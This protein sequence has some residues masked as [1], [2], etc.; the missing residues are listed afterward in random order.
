[1]AIKGAY[2]A[3][4]VADICLGAHIKSRGSGALSYIDRIYENP[5]GNRKN[6]TDNAYVGFLLTRLLSSRSSPRQRRL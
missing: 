4:A 2:S 6:G 3:V 1:M 5:P